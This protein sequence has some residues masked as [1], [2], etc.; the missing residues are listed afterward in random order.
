MVLYTFIIECDIMWYGV[1]LWSMWVSCSGRS[2]GGIV[3]KEVLGGVGESVEAHQ[4]S[5]AIVKTLLW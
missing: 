4:C 5:S 3:P 2:R 1:S